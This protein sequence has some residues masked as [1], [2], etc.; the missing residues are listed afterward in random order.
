MLHHANSNLEGEIRFADE[1]IRFNSPLFGDY[2]F[3]NLLAAACVGKHFGVAG[4]KISNAICGY[5]PANNRS[6]RLTHAGNEFILD[7]YNANPT[8]M[9]AALENFAAMKADFKLPILA[10]MFELGE[11]SAQAHEEIVRLLQELGF[12]QAA[13]V[14]PAFARAL[15]TTPGDYLSFEN[16]DALKEWFSKQPFNGG[17]FLLKGSRKMQLEKLLAN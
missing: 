1:T 5:T 7:A 10:D 12:S 16:V 8:S 4:E 17:L 9:R 14:G 15:K 11:E 6:Q 13:L 2:N 3:Y